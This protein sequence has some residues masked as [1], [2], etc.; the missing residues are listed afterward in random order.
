MSMKNPLT[1]AGI[2]PST[3][4][5]V[6]QHLN[7]CATAVHY[8]VRRVS[9][10]CPVLGLLSSGMFCFFTSLSPHFLFCI[11]REMLHLKHLS[12]FLRFY[13][14]WLSFILSFSFVFRCI[15]PQAKII[16]R[17]FF[18]SFHWY[19]SQLWALACRTMSFHFF[20]SAINSFH[21]ITPST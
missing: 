4:R 11:L 1:P 5:I 6:A 20:L 10:S 9:S 16:R 19:Y 17:F 7:H 2:E 14:S 13:D 8:L 12:L 18:F 15:R 3:F 21:L